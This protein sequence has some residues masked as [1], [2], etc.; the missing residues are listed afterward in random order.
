MNSASFD[1]LIV[2]LPEWI[3]YEQLILTHD[4]YYLNVNVMEELRNTETASLFPT[5]L[6]QSKVYPTNQRVDVLKRPLLL[7]RLDECLDATLSLVCAPA[8][9]GKSTLLADWRSKLLQDNIKVC[10]LSLEQADNDAFQFLTYI[11]YSLYNGGVDFSRA[12]IT[13]KFQ[14]ST[15]SLR[16]FLSVIY[17]VI[18]THESKC[19]LIMDDFENLNEETVDGIINPLL[20][21]AP[22][23]LHLAIAGR[24]DHTLKLAKMEIEGQVVRL[25][26]QSLN[27]TQRELDVFFED[28]LP[29]KTIRKIY[30]LTEGWPVTIQMIRS[31]LK[32][33]RDIER[34]LA[35][36][37]SSSSI[38]TTYL[39]EQIFEGIESGLQDFLTE[40]S[41]TE[42]ISC[43]MA[44]YL[45]ERE[46]S[47]IWFDSCSTLSTLVLPVEKV[48][49]AYRLHPIFRE[50][51]HH[52][53]LTTRPDRAAILHLRAADWFAGK[54]NLVRAVGHA[55]KAGE[56]R[57]AVEIIEREGGVIVWLREGL[58]RLRSVMR[59]LDDKTISAA[60]RITS[61][62]CILDIKAG[63]VYQARNRY[64]AVLERYRKIQ[65]E[66]DKEEQERT[67]HELMLV[68]SLLACYQGKML[69]EKFCSQLTQNISGI[70]REDHASLGYHFNLLCVAYAQRGMLREARH[71][72]ETA[73][74]E[75]R[76]IGS[77]YGEVY[78]NFHLGDICFAEGNSIQAKEHYQT[79]LKLTRRHFNDD[80]CMKLIAKVFI[81]ELNYELNQLQGLSTITASIPK[82]LEE[83]EAWFDIYAAGYTT[84]S[85]VEFDKHGIDAAEMMLERSLYY[86]KAQKLLHLTNLLSFQRI[87]LLLRTGLDSKALRVLKESG[88]GVGELSKP[89]QERHCLARKTG[90][91]LCH[92]PDTTQRK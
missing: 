26:V 45:R 15:L 81:A 29:A 52:R 92:Y 50:Y 34:V 90:G 88:V 33:D 42:D 41:L 30:Q 13:E 1:Y 36:L 20:H 84:A 85:N 8:G 55:V 62:Q 64:D 6:I 58:T 2:C 87:E 21:H 72:A 43:D 46:D 60:P 7:K 10:W 83:R 12:G 17:R 79:G 78:I 70:D 9:Y 89:G 63:K 67:E 32:V 22:A 5:W 16:T 53:L 91:R 19:V 74:R 86:A 18:E 80:L 28:Y 38:I 51:L 82:Q 23:N 40:V 24:D 44:N 4:R 61:I 65:D 75:Y 48:E 3:V 47:E 35:R 11:A 25:P 73:I 69:S 68:E 66:T 77:L 57:R 71:H 14:F 37:T 31:S 39:S 76:L 54:G 56:P 59:L 49:S 27:F